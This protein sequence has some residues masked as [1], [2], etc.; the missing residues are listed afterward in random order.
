MCLVEG[1]SQ[2]FAWLFCKRELHI[3]IFFG[4]GP[5]LFCAWNYGSFS[6]RWS[7]VGERA[8]FTTMTWLFC[9]RDGTQLG[10]VT[11]SCCVARCCVARCCVPSLWLQ[12]WLEIVVYG[13]AAIS[14]LLK[15][16]GLFCKRTLQK[17]LY[18][19][20]ETY[21]FKEPTTR[22]HPITHDLELHNNWSWL[23]AWRACDSV[24]VICKVIF[25][26]VR[27]WKWCEMVRDRKCYA[28]W[29]LIESGM[30]CNQMHHGHA[31]AIHSVSVCDMHSDIQCGSYVGWFERVRDK[32][33]YAIWVLI[34]SGMRCNQMHRRHASGIHLDSHLKVICNV[35]LF[36]NCTVSFDCVLKHC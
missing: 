31:S 24:I 33:W 28:M 1:K 5:W 12:V 19:A 25:Y 13:V 21:N 10:V 30:Q 2:L 17:R 27:S 20:K 36:L 14:R 9:K 32:K 22:S 4:K 15:V 11:R 16:I 34:E 23:I 6:K 8:M 26:A 3:D 18:S 7:S 35:K 29:L